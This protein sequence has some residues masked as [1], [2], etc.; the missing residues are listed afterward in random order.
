MPLVRRET[1][2]IHDELFFEVNYHVAYEPMRAVRTKRWKYIK[3]FDGR[4][5]PVLTNCDDS[6]SKLV[7]LEHGWKDRK[8]PEE[9]LYDLFFDPNETNNLIEDVDSQT[10]LKDIRYCLE[11]WMKETNDFY[12]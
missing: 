3:R 5:T 2:H 7:W 9:S 11:K 1:D 8:V 10:I 4:S 12:I 6:E